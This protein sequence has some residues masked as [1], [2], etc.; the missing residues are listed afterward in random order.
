MH[1]IE[2]IGPSDTARHHMPSGWEEVRYEH[3]STIIVARAVAYQDEH[4]HW[5]AL[6]VAPGRQKPPFELRG[7]NAGV[8]LEL[9]AKLAG[10]STDQVEQLPEAGD[11]TYQ[12][13]R[14]RDMA[15]VC[16][17]WLDWVFAQPVREASWLP[18]ITHKGVTYIGPDDQL[19]ELTCDQWM[20]CDTLMQVYQAAEEPKA[21]ALGLDNLL[22][23][24]Y[25][26]AGPWTSLRI[27]EHARALADLPLETK[28]I[29][30]FNYEAL[31]NRLPMQYPRVF[32]GG[33][34]APA[35]SGTF[36]IANKVGEKGV[37]GTVPEVKSH[38][39]HDVLN[40]MEDALFDDEQAAAALKEAK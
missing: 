3:L 31:R 34:G 36:Y 22:G 38:R 17:P 9:F 26:P 30:L 12:T 18:R 7:D 29:A 23:A 13:R 5:N 25:Q 28:F 37:Y 11:L 39:M 4:Q 10:L 20:W 27:E 14:G 6:K 19:N 24:L 35:P 33:G 16:L 21:K 8:R 15:W 2:L 32:K 40:Y 1:A